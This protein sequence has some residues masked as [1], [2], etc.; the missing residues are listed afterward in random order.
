MILLAIINAAAGA[1]LPDFFAIIF[2]DDRAA[3]NIQINAT[4]CNNVTL[5]HFMNVVKVD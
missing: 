1:Y 3:V 5:L 2:I 4:L